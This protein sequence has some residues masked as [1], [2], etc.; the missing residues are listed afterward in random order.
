VAPVVTMVI[1]LF[2][3]TKCEKCLECVSVAVETFGAL[4]GAA[5]NFA[6]LLGEVAGH[7]YLVPWRELVLTEECWSFAGESSRLS[8]GQRANTTSG[9]R[10]YFSLL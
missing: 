3:M 10:P 8:R 7:P 1:R 6:E 9:S 2:Q 4:P 5:D